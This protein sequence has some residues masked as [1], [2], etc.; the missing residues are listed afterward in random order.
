M[1]KMQPIAITLL[2]AAFLLEQ[3]VAYPSYQPDVPY[4]VAFNSGGGKGTA[5]GHKGGNAVGRRS[6]QFGV[7]YLSAGGNWLSG[8]CQADSDDDG[9]TN[10]EELGDPNC[11]WIRGQ[12]PP[13][14]LTSDPT[15]AQS[16]PDN[17]LF[18]TP[19]DI[20]VYAHGIMMLL[21]WVGAVPFGIIQ[22]TLYKKDTSGEYNW[23]QAHQRANFVGVVLTV[24][25]FII[26][27]AFGPGVA[28]IT[29]TIHGIIGTVVVAAGVLQ[30]VSG[31][32]RA[33]NPPEGEAKSCTRLLW[34]FQHQWVG[35]ITFFLALGAI[36]TGMPLGFGGDLANIVGI[37]ILIL[38][39][40][41][42]LG[43]V[44]FVVSVRDG[45]VKA[46]FE[47]DVK[48]KAMLKA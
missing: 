13:L 30:I 35:R 48:D 12:V 22:A 44:F 46:P 9:F 2:F 11:T 16:T 20:Y 43:S 7:D 5:L 24:V 40:L 1:L 21:A 31:A 6:N 23:F 19:V 26:M 34:E 36:Y 25:A 29:A 8:L 47:Q 14:P 28:G 45:R 10:G 32:L 37:G 41:G 39:V 18:D 3:V 15:N 17:P 4:G 27:F 38:G 42:A 33:H